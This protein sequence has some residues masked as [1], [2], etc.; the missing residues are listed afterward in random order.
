MIAP[1]KLAAIQTNRIAL[2]TMMIG[3]IAPPYSA[4]RVICG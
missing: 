3:S 1:T 4:S 2:L